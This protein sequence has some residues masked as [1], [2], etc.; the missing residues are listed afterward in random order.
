M[1][2]LLL[3]ACAIAAVAQNPTTIGI[4]V[5]NSITGAPIP[6]VTVVVSGERGGRVW[7]RTDAGGVFKAQ[8]DTGGSF[9]LTESRKGYRMSGGATGKSIEIKSGIENSIRVEMLPLG[10][11]AGRVV[12]QFG[13]PV[14]SV[15]V[16]TED[17]VE[18][19]GVGEHYQSSATGMTDD[20][21]EYRVADVG[22]GKHYVA[23]EYSSA[24]IQRTPGVRTRRDV[25]QTGGLVLYPSALGLDEAQEVEVGAGVTMRLNDV[26]LNVQP[27]VTIRGRVK[28]APTGTMTTL[29]LERASKLALA[30]FTA[31]QGVQIDSDGQFKVEVALPGK[32]VLLASD[33]S[34]GKT[35]KP[36]TLEIRDKD[37]AGLELELNTS[38][39]LRGRIALEGSGSLDFSKIRL[40]FGGTPVAIDS[41]GRFQSSLGGEKGAF[42]LQQLPAGWYVK[43]VLIGHKQ[44]TGRVFEVGP[45][46]TDVAITL[47][48][49]AARVTV[50]VEGKPVMGGAMMVVLI[51]ENGPIP[52]PELLPHAEATDSSGVFVIPTVAPGAYRVFTL[53]VTNWA[54]VMM[55]HVLVE[56]H[57]E[58]GT[59]VQVAE[60]EQ[61][62]VVV[63]A[64]RIPLE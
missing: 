32:Y 58:M 47:S 22:P 15:I 41:E 8:L 21:G 43:E 55:P 44:V 50:R 2:R 9:L 28:A 31:I 36:L 63:Q 4:T 34:T 1:K 25:P 6:A 10:I 49:R 45:G 39:E 24:H 27:V 42:F 60:G 35:S 3:A 13:D 16:S 30:S 11:L 61:K 48:S 62:T 53:D 14:R 17:R 40:S 12:D 20:L 29:A 26:R 57:R 33:P 46:T 37:I 19:P 7:G 38:Y 51:P 64:A 23:F 18:V 56:K 59:L 54:L 52:D 5:V